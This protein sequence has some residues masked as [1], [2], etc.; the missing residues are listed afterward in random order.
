MTI[1]VAVVGLSP[2]AQPRAQDSAGKSS[3]RIPG[4]LSTAQLDP[5]LRSR[6]RELRFSPNGAYI[7]LQDES[8]AYVIATNPLHVVSGLRASQ[9]LPI[10]FSPD[11]QAIVVATLDMQVGRYS[12]NGDKESTAGFSE[13]EPDVARQSF[14]SME[15]FTRAS[16]L[17][18]S[19]VFFGCAQV[20][21][22]LADT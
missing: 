10:R 18:P 6:L 14:H 19:C 12:V 15:N 17:I 2:D 13:M 11:S 5:P 16:T 7:L 4:L 3:D 8:A 21:R 20:S 9:S 1:A 22:C